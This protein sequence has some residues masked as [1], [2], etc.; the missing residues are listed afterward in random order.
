MGEEETLR[1]NRTICPGGSKGEEKGRESRRMERAE[2]YATSWTPEGRRKV[3]EREEGTGNERQGKKGQGGRKEAKGKGGRERTERNR[4]P[5]S[6]L[7]NMP[8]LTPKKG[9][10][11]RKKREEKR[12]KRVKEDKGEGK[13]TGKPISKGGKEDMRGYEREKREIPK[14]ELNNMP[15]LTRRE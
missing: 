7:S 4:R 13:E 6:E 10:R 2:Q 5:K 12:E 9:R 3:E 15:K 14:S 1:M 11:R 8:K